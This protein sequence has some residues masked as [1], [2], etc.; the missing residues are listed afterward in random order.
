MADESI[1]SKAAEALENC[2]TLLGARLTEE[3][4][5]VILSNSKTVLSEGTL[6]SYFEKL[7]RLYPDLLYPSVGKL[8]VM[9]FP[10]SNAIK[11]LY[12]SKSANRQDILRSILKELRSDNLQTTIKLLSELEVGA[13]DLPKDHNDKAELIVALTVGSQGAHGTPANFRQ[14]VQIV[15]AN[16][17]PDSIKYQA[18]IGLG[19]ILRGHP[20]YL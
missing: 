2:I 3:N 12:N 20:E 5:L 7:C 18:S 1:K 10:P 19:L 6:A 11:A 8:I 17:Q 9:R 14:F 13:S 15:L 4:A 16:D